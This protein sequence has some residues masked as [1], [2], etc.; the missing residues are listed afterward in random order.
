MCHK[1]D[2]DFSFFLLEEVTLVLENVSILP[3]NTVYILNVDLSKIEYLSSFNG[4]LQSV[5]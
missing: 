2:H 1:T 3:V 4:C 5:F